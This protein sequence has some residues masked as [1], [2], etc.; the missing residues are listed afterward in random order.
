MAE[1]KN[2]DAYFSR[3]VRNS[4]KDEYRANDNYYNHVSSVGDANDLQQE[5][6]KHKGASE[7]EANSVEWLLSEANVDNW[8]MLMDDA[9]LHSALLRLKPEEIQCLYL[10]Y[11]LRYSNI[12]AGAYFGMTPNAV[13]KWKR[14]LIGAVKKHF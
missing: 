8:L 5:C 4:Y 13:A 10:L 6:A 7:H 14:R 1:I 9:R 11:V 2:P 3:I 12:E